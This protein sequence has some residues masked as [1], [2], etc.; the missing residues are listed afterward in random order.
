MIHL[1]TEAPSQ[2]L[3]DH[4]ALLQGAE[5]KKALDVACGKGRNALLLAANG[6]AGP[7]AEPVT[8]THLRTH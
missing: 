7:G 3:A 1:H 4:I 2:Y 8:Y 6:L 5:D